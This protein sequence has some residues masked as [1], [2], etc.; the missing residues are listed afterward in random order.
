MIVTG[1]L[2]VGGPLV[3]FGIGLGPA[4]PTPTPTPTPPLVVVT[5]SGGG[6]PISPRYTSL[7]KT[8]HFPGMKEVISRDD[9]E[10]L[11]IIAQ[12][13]TNRILH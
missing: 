7:T 3:T 11:S 4:T 9:E 8:K 1:G 13:L 6:G 10:I 12:A 5:Q 2:G